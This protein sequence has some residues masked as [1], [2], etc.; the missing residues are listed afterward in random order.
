MHSF[1][2]H[3][4]AA[5]LLKNCGKLINK[6]RKQLRQQVAGDFYEQKLTVLRRKNRSI[7]NQPSK[8][9]QVSKNLFESFGSTPY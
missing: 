1:R 3:D 8:E 2:W 7:P 5:N 6:R 4:K 9:P